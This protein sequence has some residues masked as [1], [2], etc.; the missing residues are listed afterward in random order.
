MD[1]ARILLRQGR[2]ESACRI[3]DDTLSENKNQYGVESQEFLSQTVENI[4]MLLESSLNLIDSGRPEA[5]ITLLSKVLEQTTTEAS[6]LPITDNLRCK[7]R[8]TASFLNGCVEKA[9]KCWDSSLNF[10]LG[11]ASHFESCEMVTELAVSYVGACHALFELGKF[12]EAIAYSES[13]EELLSAPDCDQSVANVIYESRAFAFMKLG[14]F[15]EAQKALQNAIRSRQ[16][17]KILPK[18]ERAG[19][20]R[21]SSVS[22][23]RSND[24]S[25]RD[26]TPPAPSGRGGGSVRARMH[27]NAPAKPQIPTKELGQLRL[28]IS[29]LMT[30]C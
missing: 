9:R 3:L 10:F 8:A 22:S 7:Y 5:A 2:S 18:K 24:S 28:S 30:H 23:R 17:T 15:E 1:T 6:Q 11:A 21:S 25:G 20:S 19:S 26:P 14:N 29:K 4:E 16:M 12:D 27:R 13:A